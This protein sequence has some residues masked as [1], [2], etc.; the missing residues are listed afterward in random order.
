[1]S[2]ITKN[3]TTLRGFCSLSPEIFLYAH[4]YGEKYPFESSR[5]RNWSR[6]RE[7]E[8]IRAHSRIKKKLVVRIITCIVV[9]EL[10]GVA[11]CVA[12]R[13]IQSNAIIN[14]NFQFHATQLLLRCLPINV[15]FLSKFPRK[16]DVNYSSS[17]K[18]DIRIRKFVLF[19]FI[20]SYISIWMYLLE[21][22][23]ATHT[24]CGTTN[25]LSRWSRNRQLTSYDAQKNSSSFIAVSF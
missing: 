24:M 12:S 4:I 1:M 16:S 18:A 21:L 14:F 5:A 23:S 19:N 11:T 25:V 13:Y 17:L 2:C 22:F 3:G 8:R 9:A 6:K 7:R 20:K 10:R 15:I